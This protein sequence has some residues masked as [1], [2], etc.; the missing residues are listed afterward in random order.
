MEDHGNSAERW[1]HKEVEGSKTRSHAL[2]TGF[3][4]ASY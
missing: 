3:E 1:A 2:R 4:G